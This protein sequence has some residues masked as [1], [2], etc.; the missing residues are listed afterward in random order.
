VFPVVLLPASGVTVTVMVQTADGTATAGSDYTALG[1][2][3]VTFPP[4]TTLQ[5]V[6][7]PVRGDLV[8]EADETF[9]VNLSGATGGASIEDGQG[10]GTILDDDA[11]P[12]LGIGNV[13]VVEGDSGVV[14]AEFAVSLS[15][16]SEQVVTVVA[17]TANGTATAGSDYTAVGP[18]TLTFAPGQTTQTVIV[19]VLGDTL[20]EPD[21]TLTV[22]LSGAGNATIGVG[23][24]LGTILND[25]DDLPALGIGDIA[26]VEGDIGSVNAVFTV[27]LSAPS[28]LPVTVVAQTANGTAVA[29]SDY[30]AVGPITLTFSPGTINQSVSVPVSGDTAQEPDETFT[31]NLSSA[32]NASIFKAQGVGTILDDDSPLVPGATP[33]LG[34]NDVSVRE[35][36][37]GT[38]NATFTLSLS[39]ASAQPVTVVAQT[40]DGTATAGSDYTRVGPLTLQ[41]APGVTTQTVSVPIVGD[42]IPEPD[43]TF[44]VNLS[45]PTNATIGD[46]QGLGTIRNDDGAPAPE[47]AP[48]KQD[49]DDTDKPRKETEEERQHRQRT[50]QSNRDDEHVEGN[51]VEVHQD[52][53][54]PYVVIANVDGLVKVVLL[55]KDQCPTVRVGDYL[56]ADGQKEHEQLFYAEDVEVHRPRR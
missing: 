17:Q 48:A 38:T 35:G 25:D 18:V 50:N 8:P 55:C 32:T 30:T 26:V 29:G 6:T 36:D 5:T 54:P 37:V 52:E 15:A 33:A 34:I 22:T 4:G 40:A 43:E 2:I 23:Q 56:E 49:E 11:L 47:A 1:P 24:G 28:T 39:A 10:E 13:T 7:V 31:V 14:K 44:V 9:T 46:G 41:F 45:T 21:E 20:K 27:S 42:T 3:M 16:A 12:A 53:D 51:V 19:P